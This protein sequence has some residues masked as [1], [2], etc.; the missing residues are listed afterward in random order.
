MDKNELI[1][2][3]IDAIC[4]P[5]TMCDSDTAATGFI[6]LEEATGYLAEFRRDEDLSELEEDERLPKEVTPEL[7]MEAF[8]RYV[9]AAQHRVTIERMAE[10]LT[11][12]ECVCEYDNFYRVS[13]PAARCVLPVEFINEEFP[14]PIEHGNEPTAHELI[15]LGLNSSKTFHPEK[16]Y[17]CWFD[18]DKWQLF[19]TNTPFHDGIIDAHEVARYM[20]EED[21]EFLS[22]MKD[23][24]MPD[25]DI[26]YV[27]EYERGK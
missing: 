10:Y 6:T 16:D 9:R 12:N 7:Y 25:E 23:T 5:W 19:S 2:R 14:F 13:V 15:M 3:I 17:Y 8:N 27:L 18:E 20:M 11:D 26:K 24:L 1:E 4:D 22:Y 21:P